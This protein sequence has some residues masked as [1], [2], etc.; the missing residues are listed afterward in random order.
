MKKTI[1]LLLCAL[2][3]AVSSAGFASPERADEK[4]IVFRGY[5]AG[6]FNGSS[7]ADWIGFTAADPSSV[8]S[9][10]PCLS[11]YAAGYHNGRAYGYL[12]GYDAMGTLLT[13][14]YRMDVKSGGIE[15]IEGASSGG[16]F[17]YGMAWSPADNAMYALCDEDHPYIASVDLATGEL[18]RVL[19]IQLGNSL[20]LQTFAVDGEG[21]FYALTFAAIS[22]NLV[23]IDRGTGSMTTV[24]STGLPCFYAQSMTWEPTTGCIYWAH[25]NEQYSSDNGLYKLDPVDHTVEYCG[26][27]G[28]GMEITGLF[29]YD[30]DELGGFI[31]GDVN[32]DGVVDSSDALL[33]LR[34]AMGLAFL[35]GQSLLAG[36]VDG[37]G[38]VDTSDAIAILRYA[39][40]VGPALSLGR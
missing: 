13:N 25:V 16:E 7:T 31:P 3:L 11:T 15:F 19:D 14:Y 1:S 2:L 10:D 30:P 17:V 35:E 33:A 5:V 18:T 8:T 26:M 9:Y 34:Y 36:D 22:S 39:V 28:G 23:R 24:M 27:I 20:G 21:N 29:T 12:Y 6:D 4:P 40:G 38:S 37:N 32:L